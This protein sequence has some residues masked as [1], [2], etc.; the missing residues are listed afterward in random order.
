M[1]PRTQIVPG[2][3]NF[4]DRLAD[5][6]RVHESA[7]EKALYLYELLLS[8]SPMLMICFTHLTRVGKTSKWYLETRHLKDLDRIDGEPMEIEWKK[9][10]RIHSI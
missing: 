1:E 9:F 8:L 5:K 2:I 3:K 7:L 4:R 6:F 10:P